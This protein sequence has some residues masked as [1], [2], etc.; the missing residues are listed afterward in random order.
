[1]WLM[2]SK[3]SK[4]KKI[5]QV[6]SSVSILF[7]KSVFFHS[8]KM[9]LVFILCNFLIHS[10]NKKIEFSCTYCNKMIKTKYKRKAY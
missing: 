3:R 5:I 4:S 9:S 7:V 8:S 2:L 6:L 1:M 10:A